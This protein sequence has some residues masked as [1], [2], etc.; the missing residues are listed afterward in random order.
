MIEM[1]RDEKQQLVAKVKDYF[2]SELDQEIGGFQA[3][4]L[5]DFFVREIGPLAYNK[6]LDEAEN[7][8]RMQVENIS[9][10]LYELQQA[11]AD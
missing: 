6:A 7:I 8:I 10:A 3:E 2:A 9:D 1:T 5:I 4:F 11:P